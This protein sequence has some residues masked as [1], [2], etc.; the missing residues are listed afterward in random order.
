MAGHG[1]NGKQFQQY[2]ALPFTVEDGELL[3]L[4]VTSRETGRWIIPKGWPE[5]KLKPYQVAEREAFEEAGLLGWISHKSLARFQYT[6]RIDEN[7]RRLCTVEVFALAVE[8]ELDDWPERTQRQRQWMTPAQAAQHV[9][10]AGLAEFL[11][12]LP[13]ITDL[14]AD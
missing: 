8:Q 5:K 2:A 14:M 7:T 3:I 6:K 4:L 10:E 1:N 11:A 13:S 12:A 9:T